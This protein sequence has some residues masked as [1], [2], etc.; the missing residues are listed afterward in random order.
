M[1][2]TKKIR[3]VGGLLVAALWLGLT[4]SAWFGTPEEMSESERR[5][6]AQFPELSAK[7]VFDGKFMTKFEDYTLD[8]FPL[9]DSFRQMKAL[10]SYKVLGQ[11]DNNGI[12]LADGYAAKMEY[13]LNENSIRGA[14]DKFQT[15]YDKYLT[16]SQNIVFSVVPDKSY[17]LAQDHGYLA[18]D[19]EKLF[20][21]VQTLPWAKY[22]DL[23]ESLTLSDYYYTDTHWRQEKSMKA[24]QTLAQALGVEGPN[25]AD[26]TQV[27]LERPFYGV[28][29]G[30]AALPMASETLYY[31]E[32][33]VLSSAVV[34][35]FENGKTGGIYNMDKAAGKDPYDMFLSGP[36][37]ILEITNPL[38]ETD[39]EL[40]VFRD[41]FGSSLVPLLVQDYA[42]IT[43]IDTRYV[44]TD[45][46]GKFVDFHGQDVL[47][48]Y[49]PL[50]LNNSTMLK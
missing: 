26:F 30:Q 22:Q 7:T 45:Y 2:N 35:N 46:V 8:Q 28:Y 24:A 19:Y 4:A 43:L 12:Y 27:A 49:S 18:M 15:I 5:K 44:V 13:P 14:L 21:M 47:M 38:A 34:K 17:Y 10:F 39:R 6:L 37:A 48:L 36:V 9:R 31:L 29:Y 16:E 20:E 42:K 33:E 3:I 11:K 25:E 32:S 41:S 23:T 50:V 40:I 1:M